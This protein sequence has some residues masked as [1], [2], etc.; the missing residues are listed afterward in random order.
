MPAETLDE[1]GI[2]C[3]DLRQD[4]ANMQS[5]DGAGGPLDAVRT[6]RC[7]GHDRAMDFLLDPAGDQTHHTLMPVGLI[8]A[9][10]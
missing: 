7:K 10:C 3:I 8:Q 2:P 5:R 9:E 4:V 6:V 1:P